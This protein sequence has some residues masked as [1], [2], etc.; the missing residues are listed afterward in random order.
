MSRSV[1]YLMR[2]AAWGREAHKSFPR[3]EKNES[4]HGSLSKG[5]QK[6]A[7]ICAQGQ[8]ARYGVSAFCVLVV[9]LQGRFNPEPGSV[10][11][12]R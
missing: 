2:Q 1:A 9:R 3:S 10:Y 7:L 4:D 12:E 5:R 6:E 11:G 8:L